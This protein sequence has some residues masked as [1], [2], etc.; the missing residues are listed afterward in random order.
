VVWRIGSTRNLALGLMQPKVTEQL[1]SDYA[2]VEVRDYLPYGSLQR[3]LFGQFSD[4]E[5]PDAYY[6][7]ER[8]Q[9]KAAK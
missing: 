9:R 1:Q 4:E 3:T 5:A 8:W 7:S 2:L 6:M